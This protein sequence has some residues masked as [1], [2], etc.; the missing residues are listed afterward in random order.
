MRLIQLTLGSG[1]NTQISANSS[2]YCSALVIQCN[3][4]HNIRI[5]DNTTTSSRGILLAAASPAP[6]GSITVQPFIIRGTHL[7]EWF[8][9]GTAAD[10]IDILYESA[11]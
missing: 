5:G 1:S 6:G 4:A 3:A 7:S 2:I 9:A 8:I 11:T 10:V